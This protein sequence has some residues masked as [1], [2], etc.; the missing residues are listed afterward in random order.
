MK[1]VLLATTVLAMTATVAAAEV[2]VSG[3][4]RMGVTYNDAS[5]NKTAFTSRAR[6]KFT[7][8]GETDGGL[9]FGGSFQSHDSAGANAG[10]AGSVFVS[11]AFG[12]LSMGDVS[13]AAE[14][15]VGDLAGVG[16]TGLGDHNE[17]IYLSN[18]R[19]S[20]ALYEYSAGALTI[21]VSADNPGSN[22]SVVTYNFYGGTG[23]PGFFST[24]GATEDT[25]AIGVKYAVDAYSFGLGYE[26]S[27]IGGVSVD[28]II[29]GA[30]G[31]FSGVTLK[32]TYGTAD[33]GAAN[34]DQYGVSASYKMDALTATAYWRKESIDVLA[35]DY[36]A[37][38]LGA[39][40]DLGGGASVV[41]GVVRQKTDGVA[42]NT[43]ADLGLN[44]S[45]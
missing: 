30:E 10:T 8:S 41:G 14:T 7:L 4:G 40:Y 3:S 21:A 5:V 22:G 31:T 12:K 36:T 27:T 28:H 33:L 23:Y 16:L 11:G 37:Y 43:V 39:S 44:F 15:V 34:F 1:K 25:Y 32:A 13:G 45:F 29:A 35:A 42:G 9:S 2:T 17:N 24:T 20:A 19:R 38:G 18:I 26:S 6:V